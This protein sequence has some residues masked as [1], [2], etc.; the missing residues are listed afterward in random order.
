M[1]TYNIHAGHA[2]YNSG[3]AY[4]AVGIL[5][6]S[7]E[8]R[9][10][11]DK[12]IRLL[13]NAGHTVYDCTCEKPYNQQWVLNEIVNKC[14]RNPVELDISIHLNSGRN[15]YNGDNSTGGCEVFGYDTAVQNVGAKISAQIAKSLGI[16]DRGFKVNKSLFVLA[17]TKS[18]AILIE[19]C[20][21]DDKDDADKWDAI[22][23][24]EAIYTGITG[25]VPNSD[26]PKTESK[27]SKQWTSDLHYRAYMQKTGWGPVCQAGEVAGITGKS[28][29]MEAFRIDWPGHDIYAKVHVQGKGWIDMH[30]IN[31]DM[32]IGIAGKGVRLE[33]ICL[34]GDFEYRVHIQG[35]GWTAW[36]K[37]DGVNTLGTVGQ[38]LRIEAIELRELS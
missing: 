22:K 21:V 25:R 19:C 17:Q 36:T 3:G 14:N 8:D 32:D 35:T 28:L 37:A 5:N 2:P 31:K 20:F 10:V 7:I 4:G 24:A 34:K 38:A 1:A 18:P 33:C 26:K 29:R 12:L 16:R 9:K 15:D 11:K 6:E 27:Q 23:C 13:I 30:K